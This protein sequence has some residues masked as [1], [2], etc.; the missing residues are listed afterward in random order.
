MDGD[1]ETHRRKYRTQRHVRR[2]TVH[3]ACWLMKRDLRALSAEK[4]DLLVVGAGAFGAAAAWDAALRGLKV[5]VIDRADFGAGASAECFKIVHGGIRYL[6][7]ADIRRLRS[8]CAE[9][10]ALL[11]IAPHLVNPLPIA[12]PTYG[13]GR[14]GKA[15]LA[16]GM[17]AYDLLTLGKNAAIGDRARQIASTRLLSR[18]QTLELFPELEQRSLTGAAVFEDGQMYNPARLVLT[19]IQSAAARGAVAANHTEALRFLWEGARV[20]GVRARDRDG[21]EEFDIRAQLVL[22]AAGPWA[23]YLLED[24]DHFGGHRRG[25]FSRDA[26]FLVNRKP[27]SAYALAVP[28]LAKDSDAVVSR[29]A[30][31]LFA[32]PW[33][34]CTLIGVWHRL[35]GDRPDTARVEESEI[36]AWMAEMNSSYPALRLRRED[37]IYA[38]C[39]LVPFGDSRSAGG[40]LSFGKESR[41]ID[42][43]KQGIEGLVTVIGIRYTTSR[44]DSAKAL[45]LLLQ[46]M[47]N[48]PGPAATHWV[49]LQGGDI[50]DFTKLQTEARQL[51]PENIRASTLNSWLRN[52]GTGYRTLAEGARLPGEA[53]CVGDT[54]TTLAEVTHAV[55]EEMAVHLDDVVLRRTNLGSGSHP[56]APAIADAAQ[57]MQELLSW[58]DERRLAEIALTHRALD[59]HHAAVPK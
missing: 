54:D 28:G 26:C 42:H 45:D 17:L 20:S 6:Q 25:H 59:H 24:P 11:R 32:V 51:V 10:S 9:R 53:R 23:D 7:H 16:A 41:Y 2:A 56:G 36:A 34:D 12:I 40:E 27:Q 18:H 31:H 22:N 5:A 33:R 3:P 48:A 19:F 1:A 58:T 38:N 13:H 4:F 15:F 43:R 49:P 35:F 55:R 57:R 30:R 44:G 52:Y 37:V 29:S 39:G 14:Q 50:D 21:G 46:Q 47:P 8:S